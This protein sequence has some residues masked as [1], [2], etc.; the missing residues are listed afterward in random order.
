MAHFDLINGNSVALEV[1]RPIRIPVYTTHRLKK[2]PGTR[3]TQGKSASDAEDRRRIGTRELNEELSRYYQ[4][5][6][7]QPNWEC[8]GLLRKGKHDV[9]TLSIMTSHLPV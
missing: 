6:V 9:A 4:L 8:P 2:G 1:V 7:N 3:T 5:G